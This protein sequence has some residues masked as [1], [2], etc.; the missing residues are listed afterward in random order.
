MR[1]PNRIPVI[2]ES[3]RVAWQ[4]Y[5]DMRLGQL[6]VSV[7]GEAFERQAFYFEDDDW[8]E[9]LEYYL[10]HKSILEE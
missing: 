10:T 1:D 9:K 7:A 3:L 8:V 5:P 2:L 4:R 6:L